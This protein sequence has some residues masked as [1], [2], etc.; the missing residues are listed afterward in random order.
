M[1]D[2]ETIEIGK[3]TELTVGNT[4][5]PTGIEGWVG[6]EIKPGVWLIT[7]PKFQPNLQKWTALANVSGA[8]AVVELKVSIRCP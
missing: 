3:D 8:L 5:L 6:K 1:L 7:N 2:P 4:V